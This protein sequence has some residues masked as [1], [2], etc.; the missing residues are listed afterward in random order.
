MSFWA[1]VRC[2]ASKTEDSLKGSMSQYSMRSRL[3][4]G[5]F[6][7]M[8]FFSHVRTLNPLSH[9]NVAI[10]IGPANL[11]QFRVVS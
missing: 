9:R 6:E 2:G 8:F 3:R 5:R 11:P 1:S 10:V 7:H 4:G